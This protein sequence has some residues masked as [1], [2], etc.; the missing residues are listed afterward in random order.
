MN[1]PAKTCFTALAV[2]SL[3]LSTAPRLARADAQQQQSFSVWNQMADCARQAAKQFPD[4]TPDGNAKREAARQNCLRARHLPV[5]P[6]AP[7]VGN[8]Q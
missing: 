6:A 1:L 8:G 3:A 5:T 4:H 7:Q 2:A